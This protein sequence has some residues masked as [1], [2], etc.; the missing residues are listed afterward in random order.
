VL[1]P[2]PFVISRGKANITLARLGSDRLLLRVRSPGQALVRV[3]WTP[4][5]LAHGGCVERDGD[6][7]RVTASRRGYL[8]LST[9]F[10][11]ERVI[12]RGR[13]CNL[14]RRLR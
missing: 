2:A 13:R 11:P 5:W 14:D 10:A 9:R 12:S 6:W 7:T 8:R 4:Y 3:R 1:L